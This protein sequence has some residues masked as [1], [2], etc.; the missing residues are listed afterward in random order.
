M[1][2]IGISRRYRPV[3]WSARRVNDPAQS[4][5]PPADFHRKGIVMQA[6][7][8]QTVDN[9]LADPLI[10]AVMRADHVETG[11]LKGMLNGVAV[12]V[13]ADR[14]ERALSMEGARVRFA[15]EVRAQPA[16]MMLRLAPPAPSTGCD[17]RYCC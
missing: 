8:F 11:A 16:P 9:L 5:R 15:G 6:C 10:Q 2:P 12:R 3:T 14:R 7:S 17:G 13:A 1:L 4:L